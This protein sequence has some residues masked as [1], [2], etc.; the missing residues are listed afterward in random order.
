MLTP[1]SS[2]GVATRQLVLPC[3]DLKSCSILLRT[4]PGTWAVCSSAVTMTN[5]RPISQTS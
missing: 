2:V 3:R 1:I 5:G 4:S